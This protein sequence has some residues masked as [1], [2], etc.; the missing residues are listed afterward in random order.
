MHR[1]GTAI[2]LLTGWIF[3]P[4]ASLAQFISYF[5][6]PN[7]C[8]PIRPGLPCFV[9]ILL[10]DISA[11]PDGNLW[12]TEQDS[13]GL[14]SADSPANWIGRMTTSGELT[15]WPVDSSWSLGAIAPGPDGNMWFCA[16]NGMRPPTG[17][18]G[19]VTPG[20]V[21]D[22]F[23]LPA[24][25]FVPSTLT[26]G[27]DGRIW[28]T[29]LATVPAQLAVW[30]VGALTAV[31]GQFQEQD[32][33]GPGGGITAGPDGNLWINRGSSLSRLSTQGHLTEFPV[34]TANAAAGGITVG[35]DG[36]LWFTEVD[37][38]KV[39]RMT[40][41]GGVTEFPVTSSF[42]GKIVAGNDGAMWFVGGEPFPLSRISLAGDV[43]LLPIYCSSVT[44]GPDG[45]MWITAGGEVGRLATSSNLVL[46]HDF[47]V[48]ATFLS[49]DGQIQPAHAVPLTPDTGYFW[50]FD[51][52][53]IELVVKVLNGCSTN[54]H[55]WFFAAGLTN[56]GVEIKVTNL[57][58]VGVKTYTNAAGTAFTPSQDT[59]AF[60]TC[61]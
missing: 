19:R 9:N 2:C 56:V 11:G 1:L 49:S 23:P 5:P 55:N 46:G 17:L 22:V 32:L 35:P 42:P 34:P 16:Q 15:R 25:G 57:L 37:A 52:A 59:S 31:S 18:L 60:A 38:S 20:G 6:F 29:E 53:N 30:R 7:T 44:A 4:T 50:F 45:N 21:I 14:N 51:P 12:F 33:D 28:F 24:T 3:T 54:N 41:A 47:S 61:P 58:Q 40:L 10:P 13:A 26:A 39:G 48:G 8:T 36:N 27:P 43:T